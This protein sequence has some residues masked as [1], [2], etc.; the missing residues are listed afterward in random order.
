[1]GDAADFYKNGLN[2]F[3]V[4]VNLMIDNTLI[5]DDRMSVTREIGGDVLL[6]TVTRMYVRLHLS[7]PVGSFGTV[8]NSCGEAQIPVF[9]MPVHDWTCVQ[10]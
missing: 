3:K 2:C 6:V 1:M 8:G 5:E 10:Q 4:N 9:F 7:R